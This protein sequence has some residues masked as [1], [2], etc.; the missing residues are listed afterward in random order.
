VSDESAAEACVFRF[1]VICVYYFFTWRV[2]MFKLIRNRKGQGLVEYALIIAGV[3]LVAAVGISVFGHKVN[4]MISMVATILP[5]AHTDD[6][7]PI[8]SGHIIE[9][10]KG[11]DG[12]ITLDAATILADSGQDRLEGNVLGYATYG[13]AD[14]TLVTETSGKAA[15]K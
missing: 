3:T 8:A 11:A 6:N 13:A 12:S 7:A 9:T 10:A 1:S 2:V 5:G 15:T 4:D 14:S